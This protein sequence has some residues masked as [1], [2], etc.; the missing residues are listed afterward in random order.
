MP[1]VMVVGDA[2]VDI[3]VPYPKFLNKERTLVEYPEPSIQGGGTSANTAVA[4]AR[5]GVETGLCRLHGSRG[6]G[7]RPRGF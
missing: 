3:I 6:S 5:L 7:N 2:T 4:L 1:E